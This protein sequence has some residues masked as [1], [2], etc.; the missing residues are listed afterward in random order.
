MFA[1][2][3]YVQPKLARTEVITAVVKK[4]RKIG[5]IDDEVIEIIEE[6]D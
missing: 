2:M 6:N 3:E 5:W 1:L 4:S